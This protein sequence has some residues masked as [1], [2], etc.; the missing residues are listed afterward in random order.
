MKLLYYG[1][2]DIQ[3]EVMHQLLKT[4]VVVG[5]VAEQRF[6]KVKSSYFANE[7]LNRGNLI[8]CPR[9]LL[10]IGTAGFRTRNIKLPFSR[11]VWR[12]AIDQS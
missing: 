5:F 7:H 8:A 12:V 11:R 1:S 10:I 2:G 4:G 9:F 6:N 3:L